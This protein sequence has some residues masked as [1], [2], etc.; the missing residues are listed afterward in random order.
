MFR[1][2]ALMVLAALLMSVSSAKAAEQRPDCYVLSVGVDI[3]AHARVP[4]LRGC[5][6]DARI[7]AALFQS[8]AGKMFGKVTAQTVLSVAA[9]KQRIEMELNAMRNLGKANDV[10]VLFLSGHGDRANRKFQFLPTDYDPARPK[11][12]SLSDATIVEFADAMAQQGKKVYI[13]VDACYS[14]QLAHSIQA[15]LVK[16]R[17]PQGGGIILMVSS[18]SSQTSAA[19]GVF[20]AFTGAI[21]EGAAGRADYDG[22]GKITLGELRL[23][24]R[25]RT[26][27]LRQATRDAELMRS[28]QD[29]DIVSSLSISDSMPLLNVPRAANANTVPVG[30]LSR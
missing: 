28:N 6:N 2:S 25:G 17:N 20:S 8:R 23:Y 5:E 22:D 13:I 24:A 1:R 3:Y 10:L 12:T 29:S 15:A 18:S 30:V 9:T 16:H 14:G 19:L 21:S 7:A 26:N 4:N 27:A 11:Q